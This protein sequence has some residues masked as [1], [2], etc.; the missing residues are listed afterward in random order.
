MN[1]YRTA[2]WTVHGHESHLQCHQP[3]KPTVSH[4]ANFAPERASWSDVPYKRHGMVLCRS[5][6]LPLSQL[7]VASIAPCYHSS[8]AASMSA[9]APAASPISSSGIP[10]MNEGRGVSSRHRVNLTLW[11]RSLI[12]WGLKTF[13]CFGSF[14]CHFWGSKVRIQKQV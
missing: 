3:D 6:L 13:V 12:W 4:S 5:S 14:K 7:T 2:R 8:V 9:A 11:R 10:A 1:T